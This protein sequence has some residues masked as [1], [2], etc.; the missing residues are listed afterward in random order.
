MTRM[1]RRTDAAPRQGGA[2]PAVTSAARRPLRCAASHEA[3]AFEWAPH[4]KSAGVLKAHA[5]APDP[6]AARKR[7]RGARVLPGRPRVHGGYKL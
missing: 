3:P 5:L 4:L 6:E 7:R 2:S 1:T